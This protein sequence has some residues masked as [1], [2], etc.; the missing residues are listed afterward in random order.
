[1]SFI[2][3][4]APYESNFTKNLTWNETPDSNTAFDSS[5]SKSIASAVVNS[6]Q[7]DRTIHL[8]VFRDNN[9]VPTPRTN[10]DG[11][12]ELFKKNDSAELPYNSVFYTK[13]SDGTYKYEIFS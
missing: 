8:N 12:F 1:M 13:N 4:L 2:L 10:T 6:T 9:G 5:D 7:S 3:S 11:A